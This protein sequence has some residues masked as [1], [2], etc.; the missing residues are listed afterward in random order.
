MQMHPCSQ[1]STIGQALGSE[2]CRPS[3]GHTIFEVCIVVLSLRMRKLRVREVSHRA[4]KKQSWG[5]K[6]RKKLLP[7][8]EKLK[9]NFLLQ[10]VKVN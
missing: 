6:S 9:T 5:P 7:W 1:K 8:D 4:N 3:D 2:S 10:T